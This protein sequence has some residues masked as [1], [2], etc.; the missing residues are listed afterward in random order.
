MKHYLTYKVWYEP[1]VTLQFLLALNQVQGAFLLRAHRI[2]YVKR[3]DSQFFF[4]NRE[5]PSPD[6]RNSASNYST[7]S[8]QHLD[9][10]L[11]FFFHVNPWIPHHFLWYK[12]LTLLINNLL[13]F[14]LFI[15]LLIDLPFRAT[16]DLIDMYISMSSCASYVV[17][18]IRQLNETCNRALTDFSNSQLKMKNLK[19]QALTIDKTCREAKY[20]SFF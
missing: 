15:S 6:G 2:W 14:K 17:H 13:L 16:A 3:V 1:T 11:F 18:F 5:S 4:F 8:G 10:Y 9:F 12:K 19:N 20:L 7:F